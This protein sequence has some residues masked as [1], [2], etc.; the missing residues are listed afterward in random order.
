MAG[1]Q[2]Y[3]RECV[4]RLVPS[5]PTLILIIIVATSV[6]DSV[7]SIPF[8]ST[9]K[10][11]VNRPQLL[12]YDSSLMGSLNV[13]PT[14]TSYFTLTTATKSLNT[15]ISYLGGTVSAV[16]AGFLTDWRG[17]RETIF[18]SCLITLVGAILMT[19]SVNIAMFLIGRFII[20]MG[21]GVAATATPTYVAETCP[22]KH[23]A[24]ALG[25][26]YSCWG[27]GTM[28][29]AGICYRVCLV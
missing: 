8:A 21:L 5:N 24:F 16:G 29:A 7:A 14:Y 13:M 26:Y 1:Q 3:P 25:L 18:W 23:R 4:S 28:I 27:V 11:H 2:S 9:E 22:P 10:Y 15:G 6:V 19:S 17:R 20:G 12:G